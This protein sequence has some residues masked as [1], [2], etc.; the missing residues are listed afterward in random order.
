MISERSKEII[1]SIVIIIIAVEFCWPDELAFSLGDVRFHMFD[2]TC[3]KLL[4]FAATLRC[5]WMGFERTP[6]CFE[7]LFPLSDFQLSEATGS[8]TYVGEHS[9]VHIA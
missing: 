6:V 9:A 2:A 7:L 4:N 8:F 5:I 3:N 1:N